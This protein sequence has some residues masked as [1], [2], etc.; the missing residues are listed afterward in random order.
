MAKKKGL[1]Y[2]KNPYE[3]IDNPPGRA[4][5]AP[6]TNK[7]SRST[8]GVRGAQKTQPADGERFNR[9]AVKPWKPKGR[10]K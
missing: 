9:G 10:K 3:T 7:T 1:P 6:V 2:D 8:T 5:K 4:P